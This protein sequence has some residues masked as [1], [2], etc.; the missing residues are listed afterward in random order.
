MKKERIGIIGYGRWAKVMV[1]TINKYFKITEIITSNTTWIP[2][3][4]IV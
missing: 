4:I 3:K 1:P 2:W